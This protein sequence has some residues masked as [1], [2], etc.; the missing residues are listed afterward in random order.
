MG[1]FDAIKKKKA[2]K[3]EEEIKRTYEHMSCEEANSLFQKGIWYWDNDVRY[4]EKK[5]LLDFSKWLLYSEYAPKGYEIQYDIDDIPYINVYEVSF[6]L[7]SC[8]RFGIDKANNE[9][10]NLDYTN[11]M[12]GKTYRPLWNLIDLHFFDPLG[13]DRWL[14]DKSIHEEAVNNYHQTRQKCEDVTLASD[15][16]ERIL[17]QKIVAV[18]FLTNSALAQWW[19]MPEDFDAE[20]LIKRDGKFVSLA[21]MLR[22]ADKLQISHPRGL[23]FSRWVAETNLKTIAEW[24]KCSVLAV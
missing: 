18:A 22:N 6:I 12:F 24:I 3:A 14:F 15:A 20:S 13:E 5:S 19:G 9:Y 1:L 2:L 10:L 23:S 8:K 7:E 16:C 21:E 4:D 17:T 11:L